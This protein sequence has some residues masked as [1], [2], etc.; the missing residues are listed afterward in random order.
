MRGEV[1]AGPERRRRWSDDE[2]SAIV[3]ESLVAGAVGRR[4]AL[5]HGLHPN[6]LYAWRRALAVRKRG[7]GPD[8]AAV[9]VSG[10]I[11]EGAVEIA[12]AGAVV[13]VAP[14]VDPGFLSA[15][16]RAVKAA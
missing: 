15:V 5:R 4:V 1:L 2:K 16:L 7:D 11:E 3:A 14:G 6:Q 8:F 13:R 10:G 9:A 12:L